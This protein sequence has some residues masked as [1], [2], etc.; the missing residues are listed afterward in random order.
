MTTQGQRSFPNQKTIVAVS[1]RQPV[2]AIARASA[3]GL[4][5]FGEN[6]LQDAL[7]KIKTLKGLL[8]MCAWCKKVRDDGGYW[9]KVETY[10]QEHSD[11]S[12]T[13]G[14]CP[15][16]LKETDPE[17]YEDFSEEFGKDFML[18]RRRFERKP[19]T[20]TFDYIASVDVRESKKS[21]LIT[22]FPAFGA[23][24][25]IADPGPCQMPTKVWWQTLLP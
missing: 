13:H 20:E 12:F 24:V 2:S 22:N 11:A 10:I 25:E 23:M 14:I 4:T 17:A 16:C 5:H 3:A 1:K 8:P 6:Y 18:E 21:A 15:E 19:C 7:V 9:K